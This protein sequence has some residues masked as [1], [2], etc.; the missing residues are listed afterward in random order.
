MERHDGPSRI[1]RSLRGRHP[2]LQWSILLALTLPLVLLLELA[3]LPAAVFLG[4]MGGAILLALHDGRVTVPKQPYLFSQAL[5]GCLVAHSIGPGIFATLL[6]QWPAFLLC[7]VSVIVFSTLLGGLL[8]RWQVLPGSTAVWGSSPGGAAVMTLMSESFGADMRLV[9]FMQYLRAVFVAAL[10]SVVARLWVHDAPVPPPMVWFPAFEALDLA[11]TLVMAGGVA[12]LAT[13]CRIPAGAMLGPMVVGAVLS[14]TGYLHVTLPPWLM[15]IAYA[16]LGWSVGLRFSREVVAHAARAFPRVAAS[17][18]ALVALCGLLA[19]GL[20][21]FIGIDPLTAYLATSPGGA[22]SV[23]IIAASSHN[24]DL[25]FVMA[26]QIGRFL[27]VLAVG[28]I[29]ARTVARWVA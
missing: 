10:A 6:R 17:I 28:P 14:A 24:V 8:A 15:A 26:L 9:A 5:I 4:A 7:V 27:I 20:H 12:W 21:H 13:A 11:K 2:A 3:S 19:W 29:I 25:P 22:D 16:L 23:A 1:T 18:L